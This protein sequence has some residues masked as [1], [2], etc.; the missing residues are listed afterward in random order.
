MSDKISFD[1]LEGATSLHQAHDGDLSVLLERL[2]SDAVLLAEERAFAADLIEGKRQRP[3]NRAGTLS[4]R[5]RDDEMVEEVLLLGALQAG[6]RGVVTRV[7]GR[8]GVS[9]SYL[10]RK[11]R[12]I[13][14]DPRGYRVMMRRLE[15]WIT[16]IKAF[17]ARIEVQ[18]QDTLRRWEA[19]RTARATRKT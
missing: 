10:Y 15:A 16:R 14:A 9:A 5:L 19:R 1:A 18:K 17:E 12:E 11:V 7:A 4:V 2:R 8:Y 3:Q 6:S 13:K